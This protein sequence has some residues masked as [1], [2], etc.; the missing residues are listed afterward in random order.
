MA[1]VLW[2]TQLHQRITIYY[3][4]AQPKESPCFQNTAN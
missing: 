2:L 1:T 4:T 3:K